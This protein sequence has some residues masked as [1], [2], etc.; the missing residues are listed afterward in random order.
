MHHTMA[1]AH[2]RYSQDSSFGPS[3]GPYT[4]AAPAPARFELLCWVYGCGS[5]G[6]TYI[7]RGRTSV[8]RGSVGRAPGLGRTSTTLASRSSP[9]VVPGAPADAVALPPPLLGDEDE[10][11]G[12]SHGGPW[13]S[14]LTWTMATDGQMRPSMR[15]WQVLDE[16]AGCESRHEGTRLF[17]AR[18][19]V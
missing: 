11:R 17:C 1:Y 18:G 8:D 3:V 6:L 15:A 10:G 12:A 14:T 16:C 2:L 13:R 19:R 7:F 4:T 9:P 5:A